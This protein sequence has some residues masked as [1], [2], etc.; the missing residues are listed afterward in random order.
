[1]VEQ[2]ERYRQAL[3]GIDAALRRHVQHLR[4]DDR[5]AWAL[6]ED[7]RSMLDTSGIGFCGA[8][9]KWGAWNVTFDDWATPGIDSWHATREAA[10]RE[11]D[12]WAKA[13]GCTYEPRAKG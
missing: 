13:N 2:V 11:C 6:A 9:T 3:E 5:A 4:G 8:T 1:M 12:A 7:V 10:Q